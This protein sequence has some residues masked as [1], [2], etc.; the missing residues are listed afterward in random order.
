[1]VRQAKLIRPPIALSSLGYHT[2]V[3]DMSSTYHTWIPLAEQL[4]VRMKHCQHSQKLTPTQA[5]R[6]GPRLVSGTNMSETS[7]SLDE[8]WTEAAK[9]FQEICGESLQKGDVQSFDDVRRKIENVN[10]QPYGAGDDEQDKWDKAK[11]VGLQ[12][13][14]YMRMLLGAASQASTFVRHPAQ[15]GSPRVNLTL[16]LPD[17]YSERC[18]QYRRL[19]TELCVRHTRKSQGLQ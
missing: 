16:T 19:R 4:A 6:A 9:Q 3:A 8:I 15:S 7:V 18:S 17:P 1:M 5:G 14:K 10:K 13:L 11:S 12:S 2:A